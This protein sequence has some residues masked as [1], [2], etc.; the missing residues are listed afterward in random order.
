MQTYREV[1]ADTADTAV[2]RQRM[3]RLVTARTVERESGVPEEPMLLL[4]NKLLQLV[5]SWNRQ[6]QDRAVWSIGQLQ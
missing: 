2:G 4:V 5:D 1:S 6:D 3:Q